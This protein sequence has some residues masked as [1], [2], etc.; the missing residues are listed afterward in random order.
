LAPG[1]NN[2]LLGK[3]SKTTWKNWGGRNFQVV[4]ETIHG[5]LELLTGPIFPG[6][7]VK[8]FKKC[9][10]V[11]KNFQN[12]QSF[13]L[14]LCFYEKLWHMLFLGNIGWND[15]RFYWAFLLSGTGEI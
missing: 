12:C 13:D 11:L 3:I 8:S 6:S 9:M 5:S 10:V 1:A 15:Q 4:L 14:F 7:F 2:T